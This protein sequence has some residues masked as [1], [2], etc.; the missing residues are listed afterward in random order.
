MKQPIALS[1]FSDNYI[2]V[3]PNHERHTFI[4]VDPGQ[5]EPVLL[6]A[7]D[8][9]LSLNAI[10]LTHH[11]SDHIAG[12][13][14]LLDVFPNALVFGPND[15]RMPQSNKPLHPENSVVLDECCFR[16]INTPG[17]TCSHICYYEPRQ[18]WLFCG[19]TLFSAGCG[20][21]FDGTIQDLHHSLLTLK[22]LPD[23]TQIYCA[24]EYTRKNLEFAATIEPKNLTISTYLK[25]LN[26]STVVL[27]LPSTMA[28]EKKINPFLRT[29]SYSLQEYAKEHHI[30]PLDS[31][32]I[33]NYLRDKKDLFY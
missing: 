31:L 6:F 14:K 11:H 12:V 10:L 8:S 16:V 27:S 30:D 32:I 24:H 18:H 1:A 22:N 7:H 19:D 2:W 13:Q 26:D 3:I 15:Q 21:V 4:C 20:R 28:L 29:D 9:G 33:F 23:E 5:S 17:H 25:K